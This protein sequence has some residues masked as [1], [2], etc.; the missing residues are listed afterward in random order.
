M[1]GNRCQPPLHYSDPCIRRVDASTE[2][3]TFRNGLAGLASLASPFF[4][5]TVVPESVLS[6]ENS[7]LV[8]LA[9][10]LLRCLGSAHTASTSPWGSHSFTDSL[11]HWQCADHFFKGGFQAHAVAAVK[12]RCSKNSAIT[13]LLSRRVCTKT[14]LP[15]R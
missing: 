14:I 8:S 11:T 1:T 6:T 5:A 3:K 7:V 4:F 9:S 12:H 10:S 13:T 2:S 15:V